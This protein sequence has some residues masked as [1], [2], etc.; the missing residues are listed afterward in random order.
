MLGKMAEI[1]SN[2]SCS[3]SS[4]VLKMIAE[5]FKQF[6]ASDPK[7]SN[8]MSLTSVTLMKLGMSLSLIFFMPGIQSIGWSSVPSCLKLSSDQNA[9]KMKMGDRLNSI[10]TYSK[11]NTHIKSTW[12]KSAVRKCVGPMQ[13]WLEL[14]RR[15][16]LLGFFFFCW[17][18]W[19]KG[20]RRI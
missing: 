5:D 13:A 7:K 4:N 17:C 1:S 9:W 20:K 16:G 15:L 18:W 14:G 2:T 11:T 10:I 19:T 3:N 8:I 6:Y 12:W